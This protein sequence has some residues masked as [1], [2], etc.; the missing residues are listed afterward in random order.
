[1]AEKPEWEV[2]T[3]SDPRARSLADR[4]YSRRTPGATLFVPP[5]RSLI[6]YRPG[7]VWATISQ[8]PEWVKHAWKDAWL[9][10]IFRNESGQLSSELI[11]SAVKETETQWGPLPRQ[12]MITFIDVNKVRP[13]PDYGYCFLMA[14]WK[15]AG[16]TR[17]GLLVLQSGIRDS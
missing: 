4:H 16:W 2:V 12:R 6:L 9:C 5:G 8:R 3:K 13:K 1:M 10:S 11:R 15:E 14:G 7:V 17:G